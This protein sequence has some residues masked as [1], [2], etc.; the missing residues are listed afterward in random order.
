MHEHQEIFWSLYTV[1]MDEALIAQPPDTWDS[2]QLFQ[3][4]NEYLQSDRK[5]VKRY[6]EQ[7]HVNIHPNEILEPNKLWSVLFRERISRNTF[8]FLSILYFLIWLTDV[9]CSDWSIPGP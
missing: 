1:D 2:F 4:L 7:L 5:F 6:W 8:W 9:A 3:F